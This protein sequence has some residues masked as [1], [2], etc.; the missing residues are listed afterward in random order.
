VF[1]NKQVIPHEDMI[2]LSGQR[3]PD[4]I[5]I[6][7]TGLRPGEK[8]YEELFYETEQQ[9]ARIHEKIFR[10]P[11]AQREGISLIADEIAELEKTL[12]GSCEEVRTRLWEVA[13]R[14]VTESS[15]PHSKVFN[16]RR[17]AA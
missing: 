4:D 9:A 17:K 11:R 12:Q 15:Q 8:M 13:E 1:D 16:P 5:D 14:I 2:H 7:F 10:A 6:V 3:Y